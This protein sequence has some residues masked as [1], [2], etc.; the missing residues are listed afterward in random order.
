V[1]VRRDG[2]GPR[3]LLLR[4][5]RH[6]DFPKGGV[7]PGETPL[8]AALREVAEETTLAGLRFPW[9]ELYRE[10]AP[11]GANK[12]ARYYLAEAPPEPRVSLPVSPELGRPEHHEFRWVTYSD[13]RALVRDRV[14]DVLDWAQRVVAPAGDGPRSQT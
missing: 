6:W 4:A 1:V 12:V 14:R 5:Y 3:Y 7:D 2:A 10:T 9:G 13:A 8:V 11:Y